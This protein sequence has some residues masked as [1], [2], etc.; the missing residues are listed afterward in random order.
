M[1]RI[2][3]L[4]RP[5]RRDRGGEVVPT[6]SIIMP[7]LDEAQLIADALRALAPLRQR[8]AEVIV[9]DGGS[10]DRTVELARSHETQVIVAP[11]GRAAQMNAGAT[12]AGGDVLLFLH[13]DTRLPANADRLVLDGL[14]RS[15]RRWG[16]FDL[17]IAGRSPL[18]A[19]IALAINLRSRLA[20][21]ASGDQVMFVRRDMFMALGGFPDIALMEDIAMS[22]ALKRIAPPLCLKDKV[23]TSG[24]RWETHGV[25]R[26]IVLMWRLRLAYFLG[27]E[28]SSLARRYG[29]VPREH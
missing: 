18:L 9:V 20:G 29:Y 27:A 12:V 24:R 15:D 26:T 23:T 14:A 19:I 11:R 17:A 10:R 4:R 8:G 7:V 3:P 21:I 5:G 22:R 1:G 28:P 25:L 13:A 2:T 6:L 16:R